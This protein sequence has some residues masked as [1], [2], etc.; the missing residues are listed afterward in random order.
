MLKIEQT[1]DGSPTLFNV[2]YKEHY[3]SIN[4]AYTESMHVF[5][6]NGLLSVKETLK[7]ITIFEM[8]F[9][10]G[11]NALLTLI[12]QNPNTQITYITCETHPLEKKIWA[13]LITHV[14]KQSVSRETSPKSS[15][16]S[17]EKLLDFYTQLHCSEWE[18]PVQI[19]EYFSIIK[20]KSKLQ[21]LLLNT[22]ENFFLNQGF[23]LIYYDAFSPKSQPELWTEDIFKSLYK[24]TNKHGKLVTYCAKGDVKRALKASGFT[25]RAK[26]GPPGKRE[27]TVAE[28]SL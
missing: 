7:H 16:I 18:I 10:T 2:T 25:I 6:N 4:G 13:P 23:D 14:S 27:M 5:I 24:Y 15:P 17:N 3:H 8:G 21:N 9:G 19:S 26:P 22:K 20:V 12:H 1:K 11:L 28:K